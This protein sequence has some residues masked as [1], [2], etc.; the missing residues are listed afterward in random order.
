M[1]DNIMMNKKAYNNPEFDLVVIETTDVLLL[2]D[3]SVDDNPWVS[4]VLGGGN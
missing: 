2:S 3:P 1:E 4:S